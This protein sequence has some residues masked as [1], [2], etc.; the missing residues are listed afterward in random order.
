M[1]FR[2]RTAF[3]TRRSFPSRKA[4]IT[5]RA[6]SGATTPTAACASMR[7]SRSTAF[8][9]GY[10]RGGLQPR[11]R[12]DAEIGQ[13]V[14]GYDPRVAK[15]GDKYYVT[16]C[17]GYHG[18][19]IGIAWT[20]DFETFH[21]LENALFPI[22]ATA[23]CSRARSTA[24]SPCCR[25]RATRVTRPSGT[26]STRSPDM[27]F[28]GR[29]RHVMSPSAFEVSAWQCMKIGAGPVPIET[30]GLAAALPRRASLVQRLCLRLRFG[31][32]GFRP[33]VE[34]SPAAVPT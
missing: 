21:Q 13:W 19:T 4:S 23:C 33:A 31:A 27:E 29:H 16:W 28:W 12:A 34:G 1:R 5:M 22:T 15:I 17:N 14:Y 3:S 7:A 30:R 26:S 20:D 9:V 11:G 2:R 6:F 32:A 25:V 24:V 8:K 10:P 18:P